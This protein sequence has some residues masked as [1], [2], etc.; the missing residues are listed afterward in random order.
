MRF[1]GL[2][3]CAWGAVEDAT[4]TTGPRKTAPELSDSLANDP[5]RLSDP[6]PTG[7]QS[8]VS[9]HRSRVRKE[10]GFIS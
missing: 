1:S 7:P 6:V 5:L 4:V 10:M 2:Q 3:D 9:N 8:D